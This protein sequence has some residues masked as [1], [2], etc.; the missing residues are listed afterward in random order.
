M[1]SSS[2]VKRLACPIAFL[3]FIWNGLFKRI[4]YE[5][6]IFIELPLTL[7]I[8]AG[9]IGMCASGPSALAAIFNDPEN[10]SRKKISTPRRTF[11]VGL[12]VGQLALFV[13]V[14]VAL[15]ARA[16]LDRIDAAFVGLGLWLTPFFLMAIWANLREPGR[17]SESE[18]I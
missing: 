17:E 3:A 9:F 15:G 1:P 11:F 6:P 8:L 14:M 13:I 2:I 12:L 16:G 18:S 5:L 4:G 7:L 10:A